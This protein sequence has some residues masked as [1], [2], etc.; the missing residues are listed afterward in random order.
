MYDSGERCAREVSE[1][2]LLCSETAVQITADAVQ[3]H[4]ATGY[5]EDHIVAR[6][7]RDARV[8]TIWEGTSEI[9][10]QIICANSGCIEWLVGFV[11]PARKRRAEQPDRRTKRAT[12]RAQW[13]EI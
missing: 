12:T 9:Q 8:G 5:M 7:F 1:A 6:T 10:Q 11:G 3:I 4:G 13:C 2:K